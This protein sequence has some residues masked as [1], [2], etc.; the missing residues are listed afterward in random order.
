MFSGPACGTGGG[1]KGKDQSRTGS[2]HHEV[3]LIGCCPDGI[4]VIDS[5]PIASV[6]FQKKSFTQHQ[7]LSFLLWAKKKNY[8]SQGAPGQWRYCVRLLVICADGNKD[9]RERLLRGHLVSAFGNM[10]LPSH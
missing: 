7:R 10:W 2:R 1:T 8:I 3:P 9:G 4:P 6:W 5:P